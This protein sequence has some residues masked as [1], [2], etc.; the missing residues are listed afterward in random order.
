MTGDG[1]NDAPALKKADIGVAMGIS[2]TDVSKEAA[3]IVLADDNFASIVAAVEEGRTI[4][5]NIRK[6]LRYLLS[7]NIGEVLTMFLGVLLARR[8]GLPAEGSAV[9]LPLVATQILW[10]NLVTDGPPALALGVD[11][12]DAGVMRHPPRPVGQGVLTAR[13]WRGIVYVGAI[14]A[15]GTL[16]VLDASLPG[17]WIEGSGDLRYAQTMAFTT[18][19]LFQMFNVINARSDEQ[20]A[21]AHLFTNRWLWTAIG[22]SVA[23]QVAVVYVPVLQRAFGTVGLGGGDWIRCAAVA[24]SVLWLRE[25]SKFVGR[26]TR[27]RSG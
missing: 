12:A 14:M 27:H 3:D 7:S 23:L 1:V 11:P 2:G 25:I 20:S 6:F 19:M 13:M 17:G 5:A 18:L 15:G 9:V 24:S 10:I 26:F 22:L 21:F 8:I 4:F 16:F